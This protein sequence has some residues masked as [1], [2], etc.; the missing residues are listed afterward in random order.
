MVLNSGVPGTD[1]NQTNGTIMVHSLS[2]ILNSSF[3]TL[4]CPTTQHEI[5]NLICVLNFKKTCS[6]IRHN[7]NI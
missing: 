6:D 2:G 5:L 7:K 4:M 1:G 3:I